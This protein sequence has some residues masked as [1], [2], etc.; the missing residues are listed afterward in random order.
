MKSWK[1]NLTGFSFAILWGLAYLADPGIAQAQT[2]FGSIVGTVTD[3]SGAVIARGKVTLTNT[4]TGERAVSLSDADGNYQFPGLN[5]GNYRVDVEQTSFKRLVRQPIIVG[6]QAIVRVDMTL[7]P[8]SADQTVE[9]TAT[10]PLLQTED[11]SLGTEVEGRMVQDAPLNGRNV[12]NLA[13]LSPGVVPQGGALSNP[14]GG[15][16]FAWG[17]YQIGG[18]TANQNATYIDGAPVNVNYVHLTALIP[19]EDFVQEFKV[20]TNNLGPEFGLYAGGVINIATKRGGNS[21]HGSAYEYLRNK[22][23]NANTYFNNL[24]HTPRPPFTQNQY[25]ASLLG[26]VIPNRTFFSA[27]WENFALRQGQGFLLTVPTNAMRSGDFSALGTKIYDPSTTCGV[28]GT[29]A[30]GPGQ[31][32]RA[33]FAGNVLTRINPVSK[34]LLREWPLP[35]LPGLTNNYSGNASSGGNSSEYNGRIDHT[36]NDK[37]HLFGRYTYWGDHNLGIDPLGTGS[38]TNSPADFHTNQ[39]VVDDSYAASPKTVFDLRIAYLRFTFQSAPALN[40]DISSLG[41]PSTFTNG[42]QFHTYPNLS[43]QNISNG[44]FNVAQDVNNSYSVAPSVFKVIGRH[45]LKAGVDL[46]RMDQSFVQNNNPGGS[47]SFDNVFTADNPET[48]STDGTGFGFASFLLGYGSGGAADVLSNTLGYQYLLGAYVGD[49]FQASPRLTANVGVRWDYPGPWTERHNQLITF[50]PAATSPL[51]APSGLPLKGNFALVD[52][53]QRSARSQTDPHWNLFA[54]RI[55][56]AY[57][58]SEKTVIRAGYGI[59]FLPPDTVLNMEPYG[60][61]INTTSTPWVPS[62]NGSATPYNTLDNP[63]PNG[64]Q[65]PVG[66][67]AGYESTLYGTSVSAPVANEPYPYAQQWNLAIQRELGGDSSIEISYAGAKGTHLPGLVQN[68]DQLPNNYLAQGTALLQQVPNPFY[69]I[70]TNGSLAAKTV[71]AGQ[72]LRPYPQ[73]TG[74]SDAGSFNRDS[75]YAALQVSAHK[76]FGSGGTVFSSYA[77]AKLMSSTDTQTAWLEQGAIYATTYTGPQ[78]NYHPGGERSFSLFDVPQRFV[79]GYT[80]DLPFGQGGKWLSHGGTALNTVVGGWSVNGI[81]T[82]QSGFPV[83]IVAQGNF[84]STFGGGNTRPNL[85]AGCDRTESGSAQS[86]LKKWFNTQCF[87]QPGSFSFGDE[88]RA[89]SAIR[90]AGIVN[91]DGAVVKRFRGGEH[92]NLQFRAEFFNLFNRVQFGSPAPQLGSSQFGQVSSQENNPRLV[93]FGLRASF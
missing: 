63:F 66:R 50:Q 7:Q 29:P 53:P 75:N 24:S 84:T 56:L 52:S 34:A 57:R 39:I 28:A 43:I 78:D 71:Q 49:T 26:P 18:G 45:T 73:F 15:N 59:F 67:G 37:Q 69:G 4:R 6:V 60:A 14:T 91:W 55:G 47:F 44:Y 21:F 38:Y 90:T 77:W 58:L 48:A 74:V 87:T 25:G 16:I 81:T 76:R 36:F 10:S 3:T 42:V 93:Q 13:E 5:P 27:A 68:L 35:N 22:V 51:A 46:R 92:F 72:L 23:L 79:V 64:I 17:N 30:C 88:T 11:S 83:A 20:Q 33:Q 86:K 32:T 1:R 82:L 2:T 31:P 12:L 9:V 65:K 19:T 70:I 40:V 62:L 80:V 61:S 85:V 8:G 41:F 54:P 89:D